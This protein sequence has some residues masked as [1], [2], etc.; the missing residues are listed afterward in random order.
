MSK[1]VAALN[2]MTGVVHTRCRNNGALV[3]GFAVATE[4]REV[5]NMVHG[6]D[7]RRS[8]R[9]YRLEER[10]LNVVKRALAKK[11]GSGQNLRNV[12]SSNQYHSD[13][14][15]CTPC[16]GVLSSWE[17]LHHRLV[18]DFPALNVLTDLE[19][20]RPFALSARIIRRFSTAERMM[21]PIARRYDSS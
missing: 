10:G 11:F 6:F 3:N 9:L 1:T 2:H 4:F 5:E 16:N 7:K 15:R 14:L 21:T 17:M 19:M 20:K 8:T 18:T 12:V 13:V